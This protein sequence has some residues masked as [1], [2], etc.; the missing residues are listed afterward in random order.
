MNQQQAKIIA[1]L[2]AAITKFKDGSL[3][4]GQQSS[5]DRPP[6]WVATKPRWDTMGYC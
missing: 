5:Q 4:T 6:H 1:N 3:L 2:T